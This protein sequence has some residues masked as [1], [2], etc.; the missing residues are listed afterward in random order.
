VAVRRGRWPAVLLLGTAVRIGLDPN[1]Y[2]YYDA[3]LMT[4]ALIWDLIGPR[5]PVP[6]WTLAAAAM[7][8]IWDAAGTRPGGGAQP[9]LA[10]D[11][12]VGF[13]V[14]AALYTI[15]AP[16]ALP[17]RPAA[18]SVGHGTVGPL[19]PDVLPDLYGLVRIET[20]PGVEVCR[21][22]VVRWSVSVHLIATGR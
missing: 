6:A 3:S 21:L 8:W 16:A 22:A 18:P 17:S 10:G 7:F 1:D 12:R 15:L 9:L 20:R 5:R 2:P 4:G 13:A 14:A 19:S 11:L